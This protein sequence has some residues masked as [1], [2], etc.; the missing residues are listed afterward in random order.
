MNQMH[1]SRAIAV[2]VMLLLSLAG[3]DRTD[4]RA[5]GEQ[6][7]PP[8][9]TDTEQ[10]ARR[11]AD[12]SKAAGAAAAGQLKEASE[13]AAVITARAAESAREAVG[14][15]AEKFE[16]TLI[17]AKVTTGLAA[18]KDIT[19]LKIKVVSRDGVVTL[20]G[21]A[22]SEAARARAEEIARNVKGVTSV[23]NQLTVA[24]PAG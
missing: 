3:C 14:R 8:L 15:I 16:D 18:D 17:V 4:N 24:P 2:S 21:P 20:T 5:Q 10:A 12:A 19:A 9:V 6:G 22:P 1:R 11:A 23:N 13:Q 7:D